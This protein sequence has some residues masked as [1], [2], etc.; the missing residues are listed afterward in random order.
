MLGMQFHI[1]HKFI[2]LPKQ[3]V[4]YIVSMGFKN[5]SQNGPPTL[6]WEGALNDVMYL[7]IHMYCGVHTKIWIHGSMDSWIC[8]LMDLDSWIHIF[9]DSQI[10]RFL[11]S[12][13][14]QYLTI[15]VIIN[16]DFDCDM[17]S[18]AWVHRF[19]NTDSW[20]WIN[21]LSAKIHIYWI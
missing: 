14:T 4:G 7:C 5:N 15:S 19:M 20:A 17:G 9:L 16:M 12:C 1:S 6:Y 8:G 18:W 21:G 2:C 3:G 13:S 10:L 11:D